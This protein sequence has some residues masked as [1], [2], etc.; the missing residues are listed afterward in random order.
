[1][2]A[3]RR[4]WADIT[5]GENIDVYFTIVVAAA[6][7]ILTITNIY[8]PEPDVIT[9]ILLGVLAL[10]AVSN[11]KLDFCRFASASRGA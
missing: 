4:I 3:I 11:L 8:R 9:S 7:S 6:L 10:L 5:R 2:K 1:M